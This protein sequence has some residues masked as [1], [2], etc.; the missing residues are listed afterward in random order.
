MGDLNPQTV[1]LIQGPNSQNCVGG[2]RVYENYIYS[3]SHRNPQTVLFEMLDV[4]IQAA[5]TDHLDGVEM[6][7]AA[8]RAYR[9]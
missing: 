2:G 3:N 6:S 9:D 8:H 1:L 5:S 7:L 4:H